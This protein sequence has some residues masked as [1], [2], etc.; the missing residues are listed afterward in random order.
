ME[1]PKHNI[2]YYPK[3]EGNSS[4]LETYHLERIWSWLPSRYKIRNAEVAFSSEK[5]GYSLITFYQKANNVNGP[6]ILVIKT[7]KGAIFGVYC[8]TK[9]QDNGEEYYGDGES[10]LFTLV[11]SEGKEHEKMYDWHSYYS[12]LFI[13]SDKKHISVGT[14]GLWLD[15]E[16][17]F[18]SSSTSDTFRNEPLHGEKHSSFK[19]VCIE[20]LSFIEPSRKKYELHSY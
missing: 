1:E 6:S 19:I 8:S 15:K 17:L 16:M 10:F 4:I 13:R 18:G 9:W 11:D 7:D 2:F 14:N 5:D 20:L 3:L 12:R